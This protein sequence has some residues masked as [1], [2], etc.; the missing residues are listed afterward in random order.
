MSSAKQSPPEGL[1]DGGL[2]L[3]HSIADS[4]ELRADEWRILKDACFEAD[5]ID[6]LQ[7]EFATGETT[8][9]GSMGQ[10]VANP[11]LTEARQHRA[12]LTS[13]LAKLKIPDTDA[14]SQR[15]TAAT[16]DAARKAAR[17]RW[18]TGRGA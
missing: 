7:A 11:V 3:W 1:S 10:V 6:R 4:H 8:A 2:E 13:M 15:R 9:K 18:G 16:S 12:T 5:I 17:A 14:T